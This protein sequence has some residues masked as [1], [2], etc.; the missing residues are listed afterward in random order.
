MVLICVIPSVSL[1]G[2]CSDNGKKAKCLQDLAEQ[3]EG[4]TGADLAAL[5]QEAALAAL[6]DC[7]HAVVVKKEHFTRAFQAS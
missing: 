4:F 6:T 3:S 7:L 1:V 2:W 5:V